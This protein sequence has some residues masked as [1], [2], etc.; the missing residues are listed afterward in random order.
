MNELG[1]LPESGPESSARDTL[2]SAWNN[3][4]ANRW[5]AL[6][7]A[8]L[9]TGAYALPHFHWGG[10]R[11]FDAISWLFDWVPPVHICGLCLRFSWVAGYWVW[12]LAFLLIAIMFLGAVLGTFERRPLAWGDLLRPWR[13][14]GRYKLLILAALAAGLLAIDR[15]PRLSLA[16]E[17]EYAYACR[18]LGWQLAISWSCYLTSAVVWVLT[19]TAWPQL[20]STSSVG[21][22]AALRRNLQVLRR[23]P[24]QALLVV[25]ILVGLPLVVEMIAAALI[26]PLAAHNNGM[27]ICYDPAEVAVLLRPGI[28]TELWLDR[29]ASLNDLSTLFYLSEFAQLLSLFAL[30][31]FYHAVFRPGNSPGPSP[32]PLPESKRP[33]RRTVAD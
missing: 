17:L 14:P 12:H 9:L 33:P 27:S 11:T 30:A 10:R 25:A 1:P 28:I 5:R 6:L 23:R 24:A 29:H 22:L 16:R 31:A 26:E 18:G 8:A 4:S 3:F 2:R 7:M 20:M 32:S 15:I 13:S 21:L 19:L